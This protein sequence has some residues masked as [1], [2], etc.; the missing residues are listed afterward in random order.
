MAQMKKILTYEKG[1][2]QAQ[3]LMKEAEDKLQREGLIGMGLAAGA[4]AVG[5]IQI[6]MT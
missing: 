3:A 2:H 1:N 6:H 5:K 4:A